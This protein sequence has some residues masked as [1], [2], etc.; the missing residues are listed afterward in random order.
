MDHTARTRASSRALR[1]TATGAIAVLAASIVVGARPVQA[2]AGVPTVEPDLLAEQTFPWRH[3]KVSSPSDGRAQVTID[4]GS[5]RPTYTPSI[6]A[7]TG[8]TEYVELGSNCPAG[9]ACSFSARVD[10]D[11]RVVITATW[12]GRDCALT[13][14]PDSAARIDC[15]ERPSG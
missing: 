12:L 15:R 10:P 8:A 13:G 14:G 6:G 1:I 5:G 3:L 11:L 2:I 7:A 4:D 9:D